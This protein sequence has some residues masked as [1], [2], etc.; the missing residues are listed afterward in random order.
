MPPFPF[1]LFLH[2]LSSSF[3]V[4]V[5]VGDVGFDDVGLGDGSGDDGLGNPS[6]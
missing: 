6:P 5:V 2:S 4:V 3:C 1:I